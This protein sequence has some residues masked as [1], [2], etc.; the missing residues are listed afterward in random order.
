[1][2]SPS[3]ELARF[4]VHFDPTGIPESV[5]AIMLH[6]VG[7]LAGLATAGSARPV[8][9]GA[10]AAL[11]PF[12]NA[13]QVGLLGQD[14]RIGLCDAP[15]ITATSMSCAWRESDNPAAEQVWL[16]GP[17]VAAALAV[18]EYTAASGPNVLAALTIGVE[19]AMRVEHGI[20]PALR[21]GGWVS[22]A[23]GARLG[24]AAAAGR[25][26]ALNVDQMVSAL[27]LAATQAAGFEVAAD[28]AGGDL[29]YGKAAGDG[30]EAALLAGAGFEGPAA[31]LEGRR[32]LVEVLAPEQHDL[33][34]TIDGLGH[35]WLVQSLPAQ[36]DLPQLLDCPHTVAAAR[37]LSAAPNLD[38]LHAAAREDKVA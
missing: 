21:A 1:M 25:L 37:D 32:G 11:S 23:A 34:V 38:R 6:R 7:S 13:E 31:P 35:R 24:A 14:R 33:G 2:T 29:A 17:V 18:G 27:G 22:G 12:S 16:D 26:V 9:A 20:S 10:L 30:T 4:A 28:S 5:R 36:A 19:L 8:V 3:R 15:I